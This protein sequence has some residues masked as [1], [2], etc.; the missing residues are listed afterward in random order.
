MNY[1]PARR[2]AHLT[3][4]LS[5]PL[6]AGTGCGNEQK[7]AQGGLDGAASSGDDH[8]WG[9][10]DG[11]GG[12]GEDGGSDPTGD[13]GGAGSDDGD[14][15]GGDGDDGDD[16]DDG[17]DGGDTGGDGDG[18]GIE[19]GQL[20]A[21]EWRDLE[22]W[23]FWRE[24]FEGAEA[25]WTDMEPAWGISTAGRYP[26]VV[27]SDNLPVADVDVVLRGPAD[28]IVWRARTDAHGEA[29]LFAGLFLDTLGDPNAMLGDEDLTIEVSVGDTT[30]ILEDPTPAGTDANFITIPSAAAP[31]E[32]LDLMFVIDTTGSMGDE[33]NYLQTELADVITQVQAD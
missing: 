16:G 23:A 7:D 22:H 30:V 20:T 12:W 21:G 17:G 25:A 28:E 32:A 3:L 31:A 14:P 8:G 4:L 9:S 27:V 11:D 29:E 18:D 24:L 13:S 15:S 33:L 10:A 26:V 1:I 19:P 2:R 6:L 5:I